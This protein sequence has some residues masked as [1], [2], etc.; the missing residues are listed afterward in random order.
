[1]SADADR[2]FIGE[3]SDLLQQIRRRIERWRVGAGHKREPFTLPICRNDILDVAKRSVGLFLDAVRHDLAHVHD[4]ASKNGAQPR[5]MD[6]PDG[7]EGACRMRIK[8][9]VLADRRDA[10]ANRLDATQQRSGVKMLRAKD[11]RC[12]INPFE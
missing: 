3:S 1:M 6:S 2:L 10:V 5:L 9:V 12:S 7:F 4:R 11:L 8:K